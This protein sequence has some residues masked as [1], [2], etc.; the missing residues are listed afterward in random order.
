MK[1]IV[2]I[3]LVSIYS[4]ATL[5][6][7][8]KGFYCCGD[9]KSVSLS[10]TGESKKKGDKDS[11]KGGCCK[12]SYQFFKVN[13]NHFAADEINSPVNHFTLVHFFDIS[14]SLASF[15]PAERLDIAN[16]G[17]ALPLYNGV[18][19]YISNCFFRI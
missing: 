19:A 1:K 10:L 3:L 11:E 16:S 15:L 18:P 6:V 9:L 4:L 14:F 17:H 12:T 7:S 8:L 2:I 13:D 5:G